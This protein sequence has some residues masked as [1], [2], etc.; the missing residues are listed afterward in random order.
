MYSQYLH[1]N[2]NYFKGVSIWQITFISNLILDSA[3]ILKSKT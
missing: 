2:N 1:S 3:A